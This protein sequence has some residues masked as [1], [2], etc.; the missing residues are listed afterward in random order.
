[1]FN[2]YELWSFPL[3]MS[4]INQNPVVKPVNLI[5]HRQNSLY[6]F[7]YSWYRSVTRDLTPV[8]NWNQP[9]N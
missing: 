2:G 9:G 6:I 5:Y 7:I 8:T 3:K 1:M 4:F